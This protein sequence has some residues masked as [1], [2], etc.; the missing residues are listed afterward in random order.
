MSELIHKYNELNKLH[1]K[2]Y[3]GLSLENKLD[4]WQDG[5]DES[6]KC[7]L[8]KVIDDLSYATLKDVSI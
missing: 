8:D 5:K 7:D 6:H 4:M 2:V 1:E 3:N